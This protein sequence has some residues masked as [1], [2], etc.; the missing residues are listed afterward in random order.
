M[1]AADGP[2]TASTMPIK[3]RCPHCRQF[4]GIAPSQAGMIVDCPT[5]GRAVRVPHADGRVEPLPSPE[6]DV[7][8]ARLRQA[9]DEVALIGAG[10]LRQSASGQADLVVG[11]SAAGSLPVDAPELTPAPVA[12]P[13]RTEP[14]SDEERSLAEALAELAKLAPAR[15]PVG[16]T[17]EEEP[18]SLWKWIALLGLAAAMAFV[19]G[20]LAGRGAR[21]A[22]ERSEHDARKTPLAAAKAE[23]VEPRDDT[24]AIRGRIT[25]RT[26]EGDSRP[27]RGARVFV[28]PEAPTGEARLSVSALLD[29]PDSASFRSAVEELRSLGGDLVIVNEQ[30]TFEV[31]VAA[32]GVYTILAV[33]NYQPRAREQEIEPGVQSLLERFFDR[34]RR[35]LG[36]TRYRAAQLRYPGDKSMLWDHSF[37]RS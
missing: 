12:V 37:E 34:P 15:P 29:D 7:H 31:Q 28:L 8:D 9:L 2:D 13:V 14:L 16:V 32:A 10:P 6:L 17:V 18:P 33:S 26:S 35:V 5:C 3:F 4:L 23:P 27:D 20:Y 21:P 36:S 19:A 22:D 1:R 24:P 11:D 30:G 25:W